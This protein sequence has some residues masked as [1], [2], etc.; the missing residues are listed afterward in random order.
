ML[1]LFCADAY[2]LS[3]MRGIHADITWAKASRKRFGR[4][5]ALDDEFKKAVF[6]RLSEG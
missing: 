2:P 5:P 1:S 6:L 4:P 3:A